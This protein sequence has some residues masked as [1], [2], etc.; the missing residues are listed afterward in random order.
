V[1][2]VPLPAGGDRGEVAGARNRNLRGSSTAYRVDRQLRSAGR[3]ATDFRRCANG[4]V[5]SV[6]RRMT[7]MR[8]AKLAVIGLLVGGCTIHVVN[9][10]TALGPRP[11]VAASPAG[12]PHH[13][14]VAAGPGRAVSPRGPRPV[15][16]RPAPVSEPSHSTPGPAPVRTAPP[17][18]LAHG[19]TAPPPEAHGLRRF[20]DTKPQVRDARTTPQ[21]I[22]P[23]RPRSTDVAKAQ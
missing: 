21:R 3:A 2:G 15:A 11:M 17:G 23:R 12:P 20:R 8:A 10:P 18:E 13:R 14:P 16:A 4:E 5:P 9:E 6:L 7:G 19:I 1:G 22:G